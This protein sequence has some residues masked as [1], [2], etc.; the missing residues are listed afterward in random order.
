LAEVP[1]G[2]KVAKDIVATR[3]HNFVFSG[4]EKDTNLKFKHFHEHLMAV[5]PDHH[6]DFKR[7]LDIPL[8]DLEHVTEGYLDK[9]NDTLFSI[10][11][12]LTSTPAR[13]LLATPDVLGSRDGRK[14]LLKLVSAYYDTDI[15]RVTELADEL[16]LLDNTI[17]GSVNTQ[18][19]VNRVEVIGREISMM[20]GQTW[21]E[22]VACV[23]L[24]KGLT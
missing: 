12:N 1:K 24:R 5:L 8:G 14:G 23:Q 6:P 4:N 9:I 15:D 16:G 18:N 22:E 17:D 3:G 10:L 11:W 19:V 13:D 20:S 2:S 7:I 21:S